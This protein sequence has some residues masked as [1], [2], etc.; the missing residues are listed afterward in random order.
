MVARVTVT[1]PEAV[2]D[3][4]DSVARVEGVTRSDIVREAAAVYLS[5]REHDLASRARREAVQDG[6]LWLESEAG[7]VPGDAPSS[8]EL[9]REVRADGGGAGS[10]TGGRA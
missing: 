8:L 10:V 9:L 7:R 4:L 2:L 6:L 5:Q 3:E 1:L